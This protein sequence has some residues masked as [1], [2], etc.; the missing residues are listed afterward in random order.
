MKLIRLPRPQKLGPVSLQAD[1]TYVLE[2]SN[3][4]YLLQYPDA[5][6]LGRGFFRLKVPIEETED[7]MERE[8]FFHGGFHVFKFTKKRGSAAKKSRAKTNRVA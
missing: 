2:D 1:T 6:L 8:D 5:D 7:Q 4:G 3:A